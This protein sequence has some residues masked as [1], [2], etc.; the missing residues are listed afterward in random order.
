MAYGSD[1]AAI[2]R[3]LGRYI[4]AEAAWQELVTQ[5]FGCLSVYFGATQAMTDVAAN[6]KFAAPK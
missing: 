5:H 1:A 2:E 3:K 6:A 4:E